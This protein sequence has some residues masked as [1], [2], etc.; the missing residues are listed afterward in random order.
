M[1]RSS[2]CIVLRLFSKNEEMNRV[3]VFIWILNLGLENKK[4][5]PEH[6]GARNQRISLFSFS[7]FYHVCLY[8][9]TEKKIYFHVKIK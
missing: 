5:N 3:N 8:I 6:C 2:L 4:T 7:F 1:I 9:I